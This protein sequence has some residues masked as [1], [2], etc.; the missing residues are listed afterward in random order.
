MEPLCKSK[1]QGLAIKA[2]VGP[3]RTQGHS[4][5]F[6]LGSMF[7]AYPKAQNCPT[8]LY[9]MVFRPKKAYSYESLEPQGYIQL[10]APDG[11]I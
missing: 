8:V 6:G 10:Q 3:D 11:E 7:Q 5:A 4:L 2:P 9:N 1:A